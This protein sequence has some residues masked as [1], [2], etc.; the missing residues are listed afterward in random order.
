MSDATELEFALQDCLEMVFQR[1][2]TLEQAVERYP[3]LRRELLPLLESALY[4]RSQRAAFSPSPQRQRALRQRVLNSIQTESPAALRTQTSV[5]RPRP[6]PFCRRPAL[7]WSF[8]VL[9]I[10]S[11]VL[12]T[13]YGVALASQ[14]SLPGDSLYPVKAAVEEA[15]LLLT[16]DPAQR[17]RL[18]LQYAERRLDEAARLSEQKRYEAIPLALSNY[19]VQLH[20]AVR[21]TEP[22]VQAQ[23]HKAAQLSSEIQARLEGQAQILLA[24]EGNL[25][26]SY[27]P[28]AQQAQET[29]Q[30]IYLDATSLL[31]E[32]E[33]TLTPTPTV[34][35]TA[36]LTQPAV[37]LTLPA[38]LTPTQESLPPG[39]ERQT[40]SPTLRASLTPRPTNTH[41]PTQVVQPTKTP[42]PTQ[43]KPP[44]HTPKPPKPT[45]VKPPTPTPKP[46]N[47][48]KPT[49]PPQPPGQSKPTKTPKQ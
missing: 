32:I 12:F 46:P 49:T 9:L 47:P 44:T 34:E 2:R 35:R 15:S 11:L 43:V 39:L 10:I 42:K 4:I 29:A 18:H 23:P 14:N 25:P 19:A 13:T 41:R 38:F 33:T 28:A 37:H 17:V 22:L 21:E 6:S 24:L 27:L 40:Q 7:A 16:F 30:Q 3:H 5:V 8:L 48:N 26:S 45:Q 36:F 20:L 1:G 31:A